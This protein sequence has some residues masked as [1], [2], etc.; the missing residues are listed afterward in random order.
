[1]R[2]SPSK[3]YSVN[4]PKNS[5]EPN[6]SAESKNAKSGKQQGVKSAVT[7]NPIVPILSRFDVNFI[8]G[9]LHLKLLLTFGLC[10][11]RGRNSSASLATKDPI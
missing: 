7:N 4:P 6:P 5:T 11:G 8:I 1:M 2:T 3:I 9:D 10:E